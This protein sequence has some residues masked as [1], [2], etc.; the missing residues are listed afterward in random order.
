M[1][2]EETMKRVRDERRGRGSEKMDT[3][4]RLATNNDDEDDTHAPYD[5]MIFDV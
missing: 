1:R 2:G 4:E 3:R 5:S